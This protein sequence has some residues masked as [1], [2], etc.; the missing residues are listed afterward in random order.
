[1]R[2]DP[3][4][5]EKK[6]AYDKVYG[7]VHRDRIRQRQREYYWMKKYG[8]TPEDVYNLLE[9][10]SCCC[11]ICGLPIYAFDKGLCVDHNHETG[12][13]RGLLCSN[14]NSG[15]GMFKDNINIMEN[16]IEYL[17]RSNHAS[18]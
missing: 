11:E 3:K 9:K 17:E 15:L 1:M 8:L 18:G 2:A 14:C 10:Q 7:Q 13:V 4:Y 16:A 5:K 12:E 6:A